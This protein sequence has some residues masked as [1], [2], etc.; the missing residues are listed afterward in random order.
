MRI[1]VTILGVEIWA[2]EVTPDT[3]EEE[4]PEHAIGGASTHNFERDTNP[5]DPMR[6]EP[7]YE[8]D[9]GFGFR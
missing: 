4:E 9:K 2:L 6:E 1:S 8:E 7:W 5:P 3:V